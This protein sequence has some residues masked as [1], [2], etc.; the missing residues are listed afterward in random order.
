M[1]AGNAM[2]FFLAANL[3]TGLVNIFLKPENMSDMMSRYCLAIYTF[4]L[5]FISIILEKLIG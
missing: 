3:L 4:V 5:F 2:L 1:I